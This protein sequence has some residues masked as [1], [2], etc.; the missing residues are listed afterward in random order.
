[1]LGSLNVLGGRPEVVCLEMAWRG[2]VYISKN[3]PI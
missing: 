3:E 1:M 2:L